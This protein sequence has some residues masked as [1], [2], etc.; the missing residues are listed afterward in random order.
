MQH[1][2]CRTDWINPEPINIGQS[3]FEQTVGK[4]L[5][6]P[7]LLELEFQSVPD[8][9]H[10]RGPDGFTFG[11]S[12]SSFTG[13]SRYLIQCEHSGQLASA[14]NIHRLRNRVNQSEADRGILV[15]TA[16]F[17][18]DAIAT[19]ERYSIAPILLSAAAVSAWGSDE[20]EP[21]YVGWLCHIGHMSLLCDEYPEHIA[22][23]LG[24]RVKYFPEREIAVLAFND[25]H[26]LHW[27]RS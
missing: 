17:D 18:A 25:L 9:Q 23:A 10:D 26:Q 3:E 12:A 6:A 13:L 15:T 4:M 1:R 8:L 2:L 24:A 11:L 20:K 19:A 7:G 21:G 14:E 16:G 22:Q 5:Q 27:Y